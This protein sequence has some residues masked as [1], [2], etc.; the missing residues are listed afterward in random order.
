LLK[1]LDIKQTKKSKILHDFLLFLHFLTSSQVRLAQYTFLAEVFY[2]QILSTDLPN[3]NVR[4][5]GQGVPEL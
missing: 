5:I 3:L 1:N 4:K 2:N